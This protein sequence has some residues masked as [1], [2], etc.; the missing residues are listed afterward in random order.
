M[1]EEIKSTI[2]SLLNDKSNVLK[3]TEKGE[4][5]EYNGTIPA[6]QGKKKVDGHYF[7]SVIVKPKDVRFYFFPIYTHVDQFNLSD[8]MKKALKGKSCFYF[9]KLDAD[10]EAEL[11]Q[12]IA[13]GISLYKTDNLI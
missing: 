3:C 7:A 13:K 9:K 12:M 5:F 1:L 6:L 2:L 8:Q 11:S 10:L 4:W